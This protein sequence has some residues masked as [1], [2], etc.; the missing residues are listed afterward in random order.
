MASTSN[1]TAG[2]NQDFSK[3]VDEKVAGVQPPIL[4]DGVNAKGIGGDKLAQVAKDF[5]WERLPTITQSFF[6]EIAKLPEDVRKSKYTKMMMCYLDAEIEGGI[7]TK[8]FARLTH[9]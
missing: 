8:E 7:I 4:E 6:L 3:S 5:I 2:E 9:P 1:I